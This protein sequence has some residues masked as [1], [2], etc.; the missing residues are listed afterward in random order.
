MFGLNNSEMVVLL[1]YVFFVYILPII[2]I[3]IVSYIVYKKLKGPSE[4]EIEMAKRMNR[5][6]EEQNGLK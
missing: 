3:C 1:L 5:E 6:R 4:E 2:F